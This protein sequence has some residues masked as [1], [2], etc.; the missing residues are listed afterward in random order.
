MCVRACAFFLNIKIDRKNKNISVDRQVVN[1]NT[2]NTFDGHF[3][4][5]VSPVVENN[6]QRRSKRVRTVNMLIS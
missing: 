2:D 1:A 5:T 6:G 3:Q 4:A